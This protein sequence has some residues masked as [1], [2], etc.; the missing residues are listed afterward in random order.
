MLNRFFF[1]LIATCVSTICV[2]TPGLAQEQPATDFFET[3]DVNV[4]NVEVFVTDKDG[5]PVP[6][7]TAEDFRIFEDDEPVEISNFYAAHDDEPGTSAP[8]AEAPSGDPA[9]APERGSEGAGA[10]LPPEDQRLTLVIFIDNQSLR[11]SSRNRVLDALRGSLFFTL[12]P[13]D[14]VMLASYSGDALELRQGPTSDPDDLVAEIAELTRSAPRGAHSQLD[15]TAI[16]RELQQTDLDRDARQLSATQ[17]GFGSDSDPG[18]EGI[19]SDIRSYAA[20]KHQEIKKTTGILGDF[21]DALSGLRGR[22]A[23]VYVSDGLEL[24]PGEALFLA[25]DRKQSA[26]PGRSGLVDIETEAR[27]YDAT[28]LVEEL[29][30]RANA[31]R[32]TFYTILASGGLSHS[33]TPAERGALID[34][35]ASAAD[36]GQ[37]WDGRFEAIEAS[38]FRGSMQLLAAATGGVATLDTTAIGPALGRLRRDFESYYSLGYVSPNGDDGEDHEIEVRVAD[39]SLRVRHREGYRSKTGDQRMTDLVRSALLFGNR[40]NPLG[41]VMEL[42]AEG[43]D[44]KG[45]YLVPVLVKFP[46]SKI[47]LLPQEHFHEGRASIFVGVRDEQGRFSPI[48]KLPAPIRIPNDKLLTAMGQVAGFRVTLLMEEGEHQVVVGVRD[49]L[50]D[51]ESTARIS[52]TPGAGPDADGSDGQGKGEA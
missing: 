12:G 39:K 15:R 16:L 46:I 36:L 5:N 13:G 7:L 26:Q 49:E 43:R 30:R 23:L 37:V 42:G 40:Q 27:S 9:A 4:V 32:V 52:H 8:A 10:E 3:V 28:E 34:T 1:G 18:W 2:S 6:G 35:S 22:K 21:V 41:V 25:W 51:V 45:R 14:R 20:R 38:N 44:K 48:Q 19:L 11:S 50:G 33:L 47:L 24:R 17:I 29:G 31:N